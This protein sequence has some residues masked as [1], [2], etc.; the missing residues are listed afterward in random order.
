[1]DL[2]DEGKNKVLSSQRLQRH[3]LTPGPEISSNSLKKFFIIMVVYYLYELVT[4][5]EQAFLF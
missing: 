4:L 3:H 1:M 5:S 2:L